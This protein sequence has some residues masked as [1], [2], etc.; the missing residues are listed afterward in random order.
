MLHL[1]VRMLRM[2]PL[3]FQRKTYRSYNKQRGRSVYKEIR[4]PF[5]EEI[6]YSHFSADGTRLF[7]LTAHQTAFIFDV[8]K[9][10]EHKATAPDA[11]KKEN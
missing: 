10:R 5:P 8:S 4:Q 3:L 11:D 7:V 2:F 9:V 6:T 1:L